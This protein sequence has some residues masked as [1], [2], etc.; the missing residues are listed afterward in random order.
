[1]AVAFLRNLTV[2][3]EP[4]TNSRIC[5]AHKSGETYVCVTLHQLS[6]PHDIFKYFDE[7][8][9]GFHLKEES[10]VELTQLFKRAG[11]SKIRIS[12]VFKSRVLSL[13]IVFPIALFILGLGK[14][15]KLFPFPLRC[16]CVIQD[17]HHRRGQI[18]R[19]PIA[20]FGSTD[21]VQH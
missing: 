5:I 16:T 19:P 6:G 14:G 8:A 3:I 15:V 4:I 21:A 11:F 10:I 7:V 12:T 20:A 1:M 17:N 13:P 2:L 18:I 9:T